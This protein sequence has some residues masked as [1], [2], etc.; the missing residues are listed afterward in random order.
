MMCE[1]IVNGR[2]DVYVVE[3]LASSKSLLFVDEKVEE[4]SAVLLLTAALC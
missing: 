4:I 3:E 1:G 2:S